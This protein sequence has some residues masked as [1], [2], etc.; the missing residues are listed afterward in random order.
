MFRIDR[1]VRFLG[2]YLRHYF[3]SNIPPLFHSSYS[4]NP[5]SDVSSADV[6]N[7]SVSKLSLTGK[8]WPSF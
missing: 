6:I 1:L 8:R 3:W 4:E 2:M 7:G 5:V